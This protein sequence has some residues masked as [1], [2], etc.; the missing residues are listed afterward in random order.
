MIYCLNMAIDLLTSPIRLIIGIELEGTVK[1]CLICM[2]VMAGSHN[3]GKRC[4]HV[5]R[6]YCAR[7]V[8]RRWKSTSTSWNVAML[9]TTAQ[10]FAI[11][12]D[13]DSNLN[14]IRA[15]ADVKAEPGR[16]WPLCLLTLDK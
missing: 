11:V 10:P 1:Y 9:A 16:P 8:R 6:L 13:Y 3:G 15:P 14:E 2:T 12:Y 7:A 5:L 4:K